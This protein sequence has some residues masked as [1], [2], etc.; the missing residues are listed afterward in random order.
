[1]FDIFKLIGGLG[2]IAKLFVPSIEDHVQQQF[3][4]ELNERLSDYEKIAGLDD[5]GDRARAIGAF[6]NKLCVDAGSPPGIVSGQSIEV[7]LEY[8]QALIEI[9]ANKIRDDQLLARLSFKPL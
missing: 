8:F 9:A 3:E 6:T 4:N 7:P 5:S 2:D 1:M